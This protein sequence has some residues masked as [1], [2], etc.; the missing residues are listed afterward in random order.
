VFIVAF[1]FY[2]CVTGGFY[3]D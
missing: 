2:L 3:K 1:F